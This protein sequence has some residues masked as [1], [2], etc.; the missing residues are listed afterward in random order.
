MPPLPPAP[1]DGRSEASPPHQPIVSR[2]SR[3]VRSPPRMPAT[4]TSPAMSTGPVTSMCTTSLSGAKMR[5]P[6]RKPTTSSI[7]YGSPQTGS[8]VVGSGLQASSLGMML[9]GF[10]GIQSSCP[11]FDSTSTMVNRSNVSPSTSTVPSGRPTPSVAS[12]STMIVEKRPEA[13]THRWIGLPSIVYTSVSPLLTSSSGRP[14]TRIGSAATTLPSVR[15]L[16][17]VRS[18]RQYT[19]SV[20]PASSSAIAS[21]RKVK[22]AWLPVAGTSTVAVRSLAATPAGAG[23]VPPGPAISR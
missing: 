6:S 8:Y 23:A 22:A 2:F 12:G 21:L 10:S 14:S 11:S 20:S 5:L 4:Y 17:A 9:L 1:P 13:S 18:M 15:P 3:M 16:T 19:S 7:M